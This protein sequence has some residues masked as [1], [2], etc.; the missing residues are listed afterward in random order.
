MI[1]TSAAPWFAITR[2]PRAELSDARRPCARDHAD[3]RGAERE[4]GDVVVR[5][6]QQVGR[7]GAEVGARR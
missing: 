2:Q 5:A 7:L 1:T 3:V 4:S 6:I